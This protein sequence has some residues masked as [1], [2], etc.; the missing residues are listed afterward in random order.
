MSDRSSREP[1][2]RGE[3]GRR[4]DD[5]KESHREIAE[6]P[7][8][9]RARTSLGVSRRQWP[10]VLNLFIV[11]PYAVFIAAYVALPVPE[12]VFLFVT[13]VYS[14]GAMYVGFRL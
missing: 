6:D 14:L 5:R 12:S 4:A 11:A 2:R 13:F 10:H 9:K 8:R 3:E 7:L 1:D